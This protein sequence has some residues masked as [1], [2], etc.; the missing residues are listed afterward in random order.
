MGR[1]PLKA[2]QPFI[3]L[4]LGKGARPSLRRTPRLAAAQPPHRHRWRRRRPGLALGCASVGCHV[5]ARAPAGR[6]HSTA[7]RPTRLHARRGITG[8]RTGGGSMVRGWDTALGCAPALPPPPLST[9]RTNATARRPAHRMVRR[10]AH[11]A[12][13]QRRPGLAHARRRG[14]PSLGAGVRTTSRLPHV[15]SCKTKPTAWRPAPRTPAAVHARR[16]GPARWATPR[17]GR[18]QGALGCGRLGLTRACARLP[19]TKQH[20]GDRGTAPAWHTARHRTAGWPSVRPT[21]DAARRH[22][23]H[24]SRRRVPGVATARRRFKSNTGRRPFL[25]ERRRH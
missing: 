9:P 13:R 12:G 15:R 5:F 14:E 7:R 19:G 6:A 22:A 24:H 17:R 23:L 25:E 2:Q 10:V 8:A 3:L 4:Q 1:V 16:R 11:G 18:G 21:S 20:T